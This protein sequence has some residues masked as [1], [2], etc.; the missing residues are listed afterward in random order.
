MVYFLLVDI[1][2]RFCP[3]AFRD[4]CTAKLFYIHRGSVPTQAPSTLVPWNIQSINV[5]VRMK[6]AIHTH[7]HANSNINFF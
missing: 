6:T 4:D 2:L 5:A 7:D 1:V 3:Y